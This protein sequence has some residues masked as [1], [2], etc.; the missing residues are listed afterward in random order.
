VAGKQRINSSTMISDTSSGYYIQE[1][2][3]RTF[4]NEVLRVFKG[5]EKENTLIHRRPN[6]ACTA[7][8]WCRSR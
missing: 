7:S 2:L 3:T 6:N 4:G 5:G 1:K 8:G